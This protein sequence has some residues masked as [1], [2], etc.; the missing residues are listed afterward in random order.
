MY[1]IPKVQ[2]V[3]A[4]EGRIKM[5]QRPVIYS[6]ED[7]HQVMMKVCEDLC[8]ER[9]FV[10]CLSTKNRINAIAEVSIGT[11]G[12][13]MMCPREVFR[14]AILANAASI[15]LCHNHPSGDPTPSKE[16][17]EVTRQLIAAGKMMAIPVLDSIIVGDSRCESLRATN[18]SIWEG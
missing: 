14:P 7:V 1:S 2:V 5:E 9:V 6:P 4:K 18:Y 12:A 11:L 8:E 3:L 17:V 10:I 13:S 16:D 15:I